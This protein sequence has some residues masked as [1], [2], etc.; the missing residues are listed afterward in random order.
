MESLAV[1]FDEAAG[2]L[3]RLPPVLLEL[4]AESTRV[5]ELCRRDW[6]TTHVESASP[7]IPVPPTHIV[8]DVKV[9]RGVEKRRVHETGTSLFR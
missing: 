7:A 6:T 4:H 8:R 5:Y 9:W 3:L 2:A 1:L